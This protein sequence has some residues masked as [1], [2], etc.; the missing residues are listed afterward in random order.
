MGES[1]KRRMGETAK[2]GTYTGARCLVPS[3]KAKKECDTCPG[4]SVI[5]VEAPAHGGAGDL[6]QGH[7][8]CQADGV[9]RRWRAV[10][11]RCL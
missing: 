3:K 5:E 9:L 1:P 10:N 8:A 4:I 2:R 11:E 6:T 7:E